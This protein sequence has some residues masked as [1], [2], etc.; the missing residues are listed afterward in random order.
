MGGGLEPLLKD[1]ENANQI[2]LDEGLGI[3]PEAGE[4]FALND[5]RGVR[6]NALEP[7]LTW[8]NQSM[9]SSSTRQTMY[10]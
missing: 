1:V 10:S 8:M 6:F 5:A 2:E 3:E 7:T 9:A 4:D